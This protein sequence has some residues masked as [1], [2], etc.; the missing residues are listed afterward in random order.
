MRRLDGLVSLL[1]LFLTVGAGIGLVW[2][3]LQ[4]GLGDLINPPPEQVAEQLVRGVASHR[5]EGAGQALSES[6]QQEDTGA[7]L[8]TLAM[9]IE[10]AAGGIE[11]ANGVSSTETGDT[12]EA[13]VVV[14]LK[15]GAE[16]MLSFPLVKENEEW[17]VASVEPMWQLGKA[18]QTI[19]LMD[20]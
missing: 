5:F 15:N 20:L 18:I 3:A 10:M 7:T 11:D 19:R 12:A 16:V 8:R 2:G 13:Q 6:L 17:K 1:W 14:T 4:L 9:H